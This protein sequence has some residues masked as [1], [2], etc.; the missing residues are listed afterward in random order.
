MFT[1]RTAYPV[2][3]TSKNLI[4]LKNFIKNPNINVGDYTYYHD[5]DCPESFEKK[6]VNF[7]VHSKLFIGKFCQIASGT[8]FILGDANH[9]LSGFSTYPFFVFGKFG[10]EC[11]DWADYIYDVPDKGDT[12][13]GNDV[14]FGH[15]SIVMPGV[16]IGDGS[17]IGTRAVVTKDVLPYSIVAGNPAKLIRRRFDDKTIEMLLKIQW[18]NWEHEKITR[19]IDAIV[20]S[21]IDYLLS[22]A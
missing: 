19:N 13:I 6:N 5:V 1:P 18:W 12:V 3:R 17:I 10:S 16:T 8:K 9:S 14:W 7:A 20:S 4:F 15:Q 2:E 21:D 11:P 22:K